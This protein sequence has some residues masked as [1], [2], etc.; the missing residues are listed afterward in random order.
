M[1]GYVFVEPDAIDM[2]EELAYWIQLSLDYNPL[3]KSS[4][5]SKK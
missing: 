5:K 4:K 1:Q 2:D 3:A